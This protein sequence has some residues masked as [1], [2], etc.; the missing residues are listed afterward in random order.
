MPV[1]GQ[2][3]PAQLVAH[4]EEDV[5]GA[6]AHGSVWQRTNLAVSGMDPLRLISVSA[7]RWSISPRSTRRENSVAPPE[8]R[9][10]ACSTQFS[11]SMRPLK[12]S[13]WLTRSMSLGGPVGDLLVG[14]HAHRVQL[15]LDQHA[16]AADALQVVRRGRAQRLLP[17]ERC[18]TAPGSA[19]VGLG[20]HRAQ[21]PEIRRGALAAGLSSAPGWRRRAWRARRCGARRARAGRSRARTRCRRRGSG[22]APARSSSRG[23]CV[24]RCRA[25]C[26]SARRR[27]ATN[28]RSGS[29]G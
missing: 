18:G 21:C 9:M 19:L 2:I 27:P 1:A 23:R 11:R 29:S 22:S 8:A 26:R 12:S 15:L 16:D 7:G 17:A 6:S 3:V 10:R 4:D 25:A 14:D 20:A 13:D 28:A 5:L 24:R